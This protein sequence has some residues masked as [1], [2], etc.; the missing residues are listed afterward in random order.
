[1]ALRLIEMVLNEKNGDEVRN[2]LKD[3]K[4]IEQLQIP[5]KNG[6]VL[7]RILLDAQQSETVLD[8]LEKQYTSDNISNRLVVFGIEATLPRVDVE[9]LMDNGNQSS[10]EKEPERIAKEELYEDIKD[11]ARCTKVYL[12]MV[13]LSTIVAALGLQQNSL[14]IIIGAMVIAPLLGPNM[15]LA[16]GITL[17]DIKLFKQALLTN[18]LG[19]AVVIALSLMLG[20]L[21]NIDP[22]M[23]EIASRT[24]VGVGDIAV[25]LASGCAG[26]LAF[27]TG[28]SATLIGV[29]V[30]VALL[31]PLVT[32]GLLFG[33]G[34][35]YLASG[36]LSMFLINLICVNLSAVTTFLFQGVYPS[37]WWEKDKAVK[38]SRNAILLLVCLLIILFSVILLYRNSFV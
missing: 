3:L 31:P 17:G 27:T 10:N 34:Q 12:T 22:K 23:S 21:L 15:A 4:I 1:M 9:P 28:V 18:L 19:I 32:F 36:A 2:L 5:L 38:A 35:E 37:A 11:N 8:L 30:A 13:V 24:K 20:L 16:L 6:N 25:G 26:V 7:L 29:M 33:G 14:T